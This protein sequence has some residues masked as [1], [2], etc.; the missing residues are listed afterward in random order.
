M[1]ALRG[2]AVFVPDRQFPMYFHRSF[3]KLVFALFDICLPILFLLLRPEIWRLQIFDHY[4]MLSNSESII[5]APYFSRSSKSRCRIRRVVHLYIDSFAGLCVPICMS[6]ICL[7][8]RCRFVCQ[9]VDSYRFC[10]YLCRFCLPEIEFE[11]EN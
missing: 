10:L 1:T 5:I 4:L 9:Y 7:S 6:V 8:I 11:V 3:L 2:I